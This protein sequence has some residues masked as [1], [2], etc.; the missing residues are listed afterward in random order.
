M[1][2]P[3]LS[4]IIAYFRSC[5]QA[6]SRAINLTNFFSFKVK[7]PLIL[8]SA[9]LLEGKLSWYPV[10][11]DWGLKIKKELAIYGKERALY[12][13]PF[14][15]SGKTSIVG[16]TQ[17]VLAPLYLYPCHLI[18]DKEVFYLELESKNAIIN[19]FIAL[20]LKANQ[21]DDSG[22]YEQLMKALPQGY[23]G[24]DEH[25]FIEK[26]MGTMFPDLDISPLED[27][28]NLWQKEQ[29][30]K[31]RPRVENVFKIIPA[32]GVGV[33]QKS[34]ASRGI[35]NELEQIEAS[36]D[37]S[38]PLADL[39]F[40]KSK[41]TPTKS[42]SLVLTPVSLSES[43]QAIFKSVQ[44]HTQTLV[45]GPPGT[46]KSFTIAALATHFMNL[47]KSVLIAS[48]NN[49]A[50]DVVAD[51]IEQDFKLPGVVIR[52]GRS[53]Y[54]KLLKE[55][56]QALLNGINVK[57]YSTY[58]LR[59]D[60]TVL[61]RKIAALEKG[62]SGK[63][64]VELKRG[65]LLESYTGNMWDWLQ[66]KWMER[67]INFQIPYW[68][69]VELMG[70]LELQKHQKTQE[71]LQKNFQNR[72]ATMIYDNRNTLSTLLKAL[73]A[74]TGNKKADY[75]EQINYKKL[76][77]ALPIW[78]VAGADI[79][80]ALPLE[81]ELFDLLIIDE[82]TQ[83]D[84]ASMLPLLQRAKK[85]VIVGDPKQLRHI[86]F[87]SM[88]QQQ[89]IAKQHGLEAYPFEQLN[90]REK[91]LLDLLS[92]TIIAQSQVHFLNE[93][94]RSQPDI[95]RFSNHNFYQNGLK[96]MT[97]TPTN[98][99]KQNVFLHHCGGN[100]TGRGH[101]EQEARAILDYLKKII[102]EEKG[103]TVDLCRSVGV[104]SPFRE[105]VNY[106]Q[107]ILDK[108]LSLGAIETHRILIGTPHAFQGEERDVML[109]SFAVDDA[110]HPSTF[111]YL[112][113]EDV[114]NVSIT[115]ARS[116]QHLFISVDLKH[117]KKGHLFSRYLEQVSRPITRTVQ[118]VSEVRDY[119]ME[120]L[121]A[122]LKDWNIT[123]IYKFYS[124]AGVE[125]DLVLVYLGKTYCI[126]LIGYPGAYAAAFPIEGYKMLSRIGVKT[127]PLPYSL[128]CLDKERCLKGLEAFLD[129]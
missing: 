40:P 64:N 74:R 99:Q 57:K 50:V 58:R 119:F 85:A 122:E 109:L 93:H 34:S 67:R 60:I 117:L 15:L 105:Q 97:E 112:N 31:I 33:V 14:F 54:K 51:K 18:E 87:L 121:I 22:I 71:L 47:G 69:D 2:P 38:A 96:I 53:N 113:K 79:S 90:Y 30:K 9:E 37:F 17:R 103:L 52:A 98:T 95:I 84:I 29:L 118:T 36:N 41:P 107:K 111:Q 108:E 3:P 106:L 72:V 81:K 39:F 70:E 115:R 78:I 35:L 16:K 26:T 28:P 61:S 42:K 100:R 55:R 102:E 25:H 123:K 43:Q 91:S 127:F 19:P 13:C 89:L 82:A 6:D 65:R 27:Y 88:E 83:C 44:K 59:L 63:E 126:D 46:G 4:N 7:F 1:K 32:I 48:K 45:I 62:I 10:A 80:Q 92:D 77:D 116:A 12:C 20:A 86:S 104:L 73:K 76:L 125:V 75:F 68:E 21:N 5:Y 11:T 124:I 128:W 120:E 49:Q 129:V 66:R 110:T 8:E 23:I 24:F 94:Y 114:F 56:I 101:N